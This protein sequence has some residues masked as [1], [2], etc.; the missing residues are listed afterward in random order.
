[1]TLL[2]CE[3]NDLVVPVD[4]DRR[5]VLSPSSKAFFAARRKARS[6]SF[7]SREGDFALLISN[8]L[9]RKS[10][11]VAGLNYRTLPLIDQVQ[12]YLSK[13]A[14][15]SIKPM[16]H[17]STGDVVPAL[18][19][20]KSSLACAIGSSNDDDLSSFRHALVCA[21]LPCLSRSSRY[22]CCMT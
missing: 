9:A 8:Y 18:L 15:P 6:V 19:A 14:Q 1:M 10:T 7:A 12:L 3:V 17:N 20:R 4:V 16:P 13:V 22:H 21:Y 11:E 5:T 2:L